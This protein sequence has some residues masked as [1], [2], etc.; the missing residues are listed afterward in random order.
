MDMDVGADLILGWD[1]ISSHDLHHLHADGHVRFRSGPDLL[2]LDLLPA[3]TSPTARTL[4]VIGHG[5]FRL[6][7]RQLT[8]E[9]P[10]GVD[11]PPAPT[12][13]SPAT[14][15]R[16]SKGWSR[17]LNADHAELAAAEAAAVQAAR[18][19][20]RPGQPPA[21]RCV[22]R[23]AD[24]MEPMME[25]LKDSTEL[26]LA[27]FCLAHAELRLEGTDDLAFAALKVKYAN[28]YQ[29]RFCS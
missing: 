1:W 25:V 8:H 20:R 3:G 11:S 17:Q 12:T 28:V 29:G 21:P 2:Q 18:A 6:L 27:S 9:L 4:P 19:L 22:G 5:E 16:S 14:T 23:F 13:P 10:A 26:H 24:G 15:P 7:L